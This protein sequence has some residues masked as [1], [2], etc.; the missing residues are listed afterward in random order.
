MPTQTSLVAVVRDRLVK[1]K[2]RLPVLNPIAMDLRN[3]LQN[4]HYDVSDV[5]HLIEQDPALAGQLLRLSNSA[6]FAGL[7]HVATVNEAIVRVGS[8]K[9]VDLVTMVAHAENFRSKN[10]DVSTY[11][12]TLWEHAICTANA[13]RWI[14]DT[15]GYTALASEVFQ[16]GIFHD[17]GEL[18]L[19]K[20]LE[21]ID[22]NGTDRVLSSKPLVLEVVD[23]LH[24]ELGFKVLKQWNLPETYCNVARQ[25]HSSSATSDR[26]VQI[27]TLAD[28]ACLKLG[29]GLQHD[30]EAPLA[31]CPEAEALGLS[32]IQL[33]ELEITIED[34]VEKYGSFAA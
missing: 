24:S 25:H 29:V 34:A 16:A 11:M 28:A 3:L 30:D 18:L 6:F 5:A 21:D 15:A 12:K 23:T 10:P 33:A 2:I 7:R 8:Q 13:A 14:A 27:V 19:I 31:N 1:G 9:V 20:T 32:E 17:I 26:V 22:A 4:P